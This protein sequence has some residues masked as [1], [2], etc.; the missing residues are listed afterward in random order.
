MRYIYKHL[1]RYV[2]YIASGYRCVKLCAYV[3]RGGLTTREISMNAFGISLGSD[4]NSDGLNKNLSHI[5]AFILL[6]VCAFLLS[7]IFW[8]AYYPDSV[9]AHQMNNISEQLAAADPAAHAAVTWDWFKLRAVKPKVVVAAKIDAQLIGILG[10]GKK[11]SAMISLS[12]KPA[13]AFKVGEDVMDGVMLSR[14]ES[15]HVILLRNN[16]EEILYLEKK[17]NLFGNEEVRAKPATDSTS[18]PE[19][20][21]IARLLREDPL[22]LAKLVHFERVPTERYGDGYK[23]TPSDSANYDL[24]SD[25]ELYPGDIVLGVGRNQAVDIATNP[26]LWSSILRKNTIPIQVLR[27]GKL[28]R[29]IVKLKK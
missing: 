24:L 18:P 28:E 25:L 3:G 1:S 22:Q 16:I 29:T 4:F 20:P 10:S 26:K 12:K 7:D 13:K 23:V 5:A 19:T 2:L 27:N 9:S 8:K 17:P 14:L 21:E 15:D 6:P 11:G